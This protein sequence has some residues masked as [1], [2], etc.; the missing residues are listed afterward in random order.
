MAAGWG[1][2]LAENTPPYLSPRHR[3]TRKLGHFPSEGSGH[4]IYV[5]NGSRF[6]AKSTYKQ[7]LYLSAVYC[8][9]ARA[10]DLAIRSSYFFYLEGHWASQTLNFQL[11][12]S[13]STPGEEVRGTRREKVGQSTRERLSLRIT[14]PALTLTLWGRR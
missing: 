3:A 9:R 6:R 5:D 4:P 12:Q 14:S 7:L 11:K 2:Y 10:I 13:I 8:T 1:V